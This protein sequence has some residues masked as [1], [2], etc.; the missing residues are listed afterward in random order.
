MDNSTCYVPRCE[1]CG[2]PL[3]SNGLC[4]NPQC[5]CSIKSQVTTNEIS[6]EPKG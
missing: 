5:G 2:Y 4:T 3:D 6:T 1:F